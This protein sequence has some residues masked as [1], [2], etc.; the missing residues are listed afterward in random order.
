VVHARPSSATA[1]LTRAMDAGVNRNERCWVQDRGVRVVL[2][3]V[4][5][6]IGDLGEL[7]VREERDCGVRP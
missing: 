2:V 1:A 3:P 5:V 6:I 7:V 4:V